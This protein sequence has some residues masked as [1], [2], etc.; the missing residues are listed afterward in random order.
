MDASI[1]AAGF[2]IGL[3]WTNPDRY[4][5]LDAKGLETVRRDNCLLVRK[6]VDTCLRKIL[7]ERC[8]CY[9]YYSYRFFLF[10]E[11]HF[12]FYSRM[13]CIEMYKAQL[14]TPRAPSAIFCRIKWTFQC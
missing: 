2:Y 9:L 7:I 11:F 13:L 8:V 12:T 10:V 5:K 4:D 1:F 14:T 6:L 3:L